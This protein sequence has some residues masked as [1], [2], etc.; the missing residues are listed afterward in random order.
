[1]LTLSG[2]EPIAPRALANPSVN[3]TR[4]FEAVHQTLDWGLP[5]GW[6]THPPTGIQTA[7]AGAGEEKIV[8]RLIS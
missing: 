8:G 6:H 2:R 4:H 1:M 3:A 5:G 7:E